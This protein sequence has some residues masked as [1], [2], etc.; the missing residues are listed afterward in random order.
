[1]QEP[2]SNGGRE[3]VFHLNRPRWGH[4][5]QEEKMLIRE[6]RMKDLEK[7][8]LISI[9]SIFPLILL[10]FGGGYLLASFMLKPLDK[11]NSEIRKKQAGNRL[12]FRVSTTA[13]GIPA[14]PSSKSRSGDGWACPC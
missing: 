1:M 11:L 13:G 7:I 8:R 12:T 2:L 14:G 10:S 5:Q 3:S 4:L 9:Y 6:S